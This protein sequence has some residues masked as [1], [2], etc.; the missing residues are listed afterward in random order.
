MLVIPL[1]MLPSHAMAKEPRAG[2]TKRP[3]ASAK[4]WQGVRS[5]LKK[6]TSLLG[7]TQKPTPLRKKRAYDSVA[8]TMTAQGQIYTS[9]LISEEIKFFSADTEWGDMAGGLR[10]TAMYEGHA[11][12][13]VALSVNGV[14]PGGNVPFSVGGNLTFTKTIQRAILFANAGYQRNFK[15]EDSDPAFRDLPDTQFNTTVG[16]SYAMSDALTLNASVTGIFFTQGA[17]ENS[18]SSFS[19]DNYVLQVGLVY[20][21]SKDAYMKPTLNFGLDDSSLGVSLGV[22]IPI[23]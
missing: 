4:S 14:S 12:P 3:A 22:C 17:A 19:R 18:A 15:S 9:R 13:S 2:Y 16:V 23:N 7:T 20:N 6:T 8:V 11:F 1:S 5:Y 10:Y 21:L